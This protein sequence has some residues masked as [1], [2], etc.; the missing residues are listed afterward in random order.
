MTL[1]LSKETINPQN[2][3]VLIKEVF[4]YSEINEINKKIEFINSSIFN[5]GNSI[6]GIAKNLF[7]IK[8]VIKNNNWV[9]LT[10]SRIFSLS[11]RNCRDLASAYE[12][13]LFETNIPEIIL[14]QLSA[15]SLAKIGN[16]DLV[17]RKEIIDRL[18]DGEIFTESDLKK[19]SS[20]KEI[21][22]FD[23]NHQIKKA[24]DI[25]HSLTDSQKLRN[26][27]N[28]MIINV[29]QKEEILILKK[30]ISELKKDGSNPN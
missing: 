1:S 28:I 2:N 26:F 17:K 25:C 27:Q 30:T 10:D 21:T 6:L 14:A 4:E 24:M 7:E 29:K 15:R 22:N 19:F 12:S 9:K 18:L 8:S 13:W 3:K 11:G 23:Y 16:F 20:K 5:I